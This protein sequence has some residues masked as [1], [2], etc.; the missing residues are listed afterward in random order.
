MNLA[1]P[2]NL[3]P[4]LLPTPNEACATQINFYSLF[5]QV[6]D[7]QI[8]LFHRVIEIEL[9]I[10]SKIELVCGYSSLKSLPSVTHATSE[11]KIKPLQA[12]SYCRQRCMGR[13]S[14]RREMRE[15][16]K[17]TNNSQGWHTREEEK[18]WPEGACGS[19]V[20]SP[21]PGC[22]AK[23]IFCVP[24]E[25]GLRHVQPT[26]IVRLQKILHALSLVEGY[27]P[28]QSRP[29]YLYFPVA[30]GDFSHL[31]KIFFLEHAGELRAISLIE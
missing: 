27:A 13:G 30:V 24:T 9:Q 5:S 23:L 29:M 6:H 22:T 25:P 31:W 2:R 3:Y 26:K 8:K 11:S 14:T 21:Q 28:N 10:C 19:Q 7:D 20:G 4:S 12:P 17:R 1:L 15:R 16:G 18:R